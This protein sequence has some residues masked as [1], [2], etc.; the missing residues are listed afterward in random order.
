MQW[1]GTP[2]RSYC[3]WQGLLQL[4]PQTLYKLEMGNLCHADHWEHGQHLQTSK[5]QREEPLVFHLQ[6]CR[7]DAAVILFPVHQFTV[8]WSPSQLA[9]S[10][11]T[12]QP[13][14]CPEQKDNTSC[15]V[16]WNNTWCSVCWRV[17]I[18]T[19]L[20]QSN[21]QQ[22]YLA[23]HELERPLILIN[24]T[25]II[26]I[27]SFFSLSLFFLSLSVSLIISSQPVSAM[28]R[29]VWRK[30]QMMESITSLSWSGDMVKRVPKQWLVM[31]RSRP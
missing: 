18:R 5:L 20:L 28:L 10:Q 21:I 9:G 31:A 6:A 17:N 11:G 29:S 7:H 3:N 15:N 23:H 26:I 19:A 16:C 27:L 14:P 1:V 12:A 2:D 25:T 13:L 24:I 4:A 30:A 22:T 8:G